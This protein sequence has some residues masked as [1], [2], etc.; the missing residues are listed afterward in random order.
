[1]DDGMVELE[2]LGHGRPWGEFDTVLL[3]SSRAL[4]WLQVQQGTTL[5]LLSAL[6]IQYPNATVLSK[7]WFAWILTSLGMLIAMIPNIYNPKLL[8]YYFRFAVLNFF[9]LLILYWIYFPIRASSGDRH[10][11]SRD[12]VFGLFYNGINLGTEKEASDAY[13]WVISTL[14]G[15]SEMSTIHCFGRC[16]YLYLLP[17]IYILFHAVLTVSDLFSTQVLTECSKSRFVL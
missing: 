1:V 4:Q 2:W 9:V 8:Q 16:E 12:G 14:F 11:N 13:V 5:F 15:V 17:E 7:G 6:Q 10:F 3:P